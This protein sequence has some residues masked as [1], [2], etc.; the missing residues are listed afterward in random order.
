MSYIR[1]EQVSKLFPGPRGQNIQAV[2]DLNLQVDRG[3]FLVIVGPSGCG[4]TTT[5]RLL[6]GLEEPST[7][8]I[9]MDGRLMNGIAPKHRDL[10][11]VLQNP[12]LYPH[13]TARENITFGLRLRNCPPAEI[14][15]RLHRAAE[16]LDLTDSLNRRPAELSGGQCQRVALG[17]ALVRQPGIFLFDE[18]LSNLDPQMRNQLRGEI[19]RLHRRL[20]A[21]SIY[22]THDQIEAMTLGD[23]IAVMH[24][25]TI[26]Q[27]GSPHDVYRHPADLFVARFVGVPEINL[28]QGKLLEEG[29]VVW[30]QEQNDAP[31]VFPALKAACPQDSVATLKPHTGQSVVLGI[32]PDDLRS[33]APAEGAESALIAGGIVEFIEG[34]GTE[35]HLHL[36]RGKQTL[37]AR[38]SAADR[39]VP[40]Q[41][42]SVR[43]NIRH[44]HFFEAGTG[45]SITCGS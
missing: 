22:V 21:T 44:A 28:F 39:V 43:M 13:M 31:G 35:V 17:R 37:I 26:R 24:Q 1:L 36:R 7:G 27:V 42:V 45:K 34:L 29:G 11:M 6:S 12:A 9:Q 23:R 8:T 2:T 32:R 10:A 4:K 16:L 41:A 30:F 19:R 38:A 25:G 3:E 40:D 5:L 18:P 33:D 14:E 20:E 15:Q